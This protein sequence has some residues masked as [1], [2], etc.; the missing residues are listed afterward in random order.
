MK[1]PAQDPRD[2]FDALYRRT[3]GDIL[4]YLVRRARTVEDAAD[5]LA[6]TYAAA[7]RK[8]DNLPEGEGARLWLFGAAR[9]ELRKAAGR[10]RAEDDL[11]VALMQELRPLVQEQASDNDGDEELRAGSPR[12]P[13]S[14]TRSS[15]SRLGRT[16]HHDRSRRSSACRPTSCGS[17]C[18]GR[19]AIS[20]ASSNL[21]S[22]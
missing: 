5:A 15:R 8:L 13:D 11:A 9:N 2:R 4:A 14:T 10:A 3:S 6:E 16:S 21:S 17:V 22:G 12:C 7:W 19:E 20:A 18:T 1:P